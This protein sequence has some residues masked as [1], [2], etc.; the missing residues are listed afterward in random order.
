ML[1]LVGA[2]VM[3][4]AILLS[5]QNLW[6]SLLHPLLVCGGRTSTLSL[7]MWIL[8]LFPTTLFQGP[9]DSTRVGCTK[10]PH[11]VFF[12]ASRFIFQPPTQPSECCHELLGSGILIPTPDI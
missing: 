10:K 5:A 12:L 2:V 11:Y 3:S 7:Y 4:S 9:V 8:M 6:Q 1:A